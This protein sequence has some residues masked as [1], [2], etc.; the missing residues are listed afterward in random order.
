[1]GEEI[2]SRRNEGIALVTTVLILAL[3]SLI[4]I[5]ALETATQDRRVGGFLSRSQLAL[6]AAE[7]GLESVART[8]SELDLPAGAAALEDVTVA[9]SSTPVGDSSVH[10]HGIPT[11]SADDTAS[12]AV[13]YLGAGGPCEEWVM[14]IELGGPMYRYSLWDIRVQGETPDGAK[15]RVQAS[16]TRCYAYDG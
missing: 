3:L 7:A 13:E 8:M 11:Y 16:A 2:R 1:M 15:A 4:G 12:Q 6:Y 9:V 5:S 14:S 10:P